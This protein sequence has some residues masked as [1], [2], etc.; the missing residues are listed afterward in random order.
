MQRRERETYPYMPA[1]I[2]LIFSKQ[3]ALREPHVGNSSVLI[4]PNAAV[5][6]STISTKREAKKEREQIGKAGNLS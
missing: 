1:P 6:I 2:C 4:C 3:S 5:V